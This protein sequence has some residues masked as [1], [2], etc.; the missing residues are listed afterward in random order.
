MP[1]LI[2]LENQ[3][4]IFLAC[5]NIYRRLPK[6]F[7]FIILNFTY[8][9]TLVSF[10]YSS[11]LILS[12]LLILWACCMMGLFPGLSY[13]MHTGND[14]QPSIVV[15]ICDDPVGYENRPSKIEQTRRPDTNSPKWKLH[16]RQTLSIRWNERIGAYFSPTSEACSSH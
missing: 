7:N 4:Y 8:N 14:S 5:I 16:W 11:D 3:Y 6:S 13:E 9:C 10:L 2:L 12:F 1:C 15:H